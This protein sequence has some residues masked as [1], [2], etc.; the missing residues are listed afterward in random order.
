MTSDIEVF[1]AAGEKNILAGRMY[2]HFRRGSESASFIYDDKYLAN[3]DAYE[4]DPALPLSA[5]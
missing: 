4:L 2:P 5:C 3:P 1:A